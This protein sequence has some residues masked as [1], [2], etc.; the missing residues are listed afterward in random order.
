MQKPDGGFLSCWRQTVK[1][2]GFTQ[3]GKILCRNGIKWS[4]EMK[5]KDEKDKME[6]MHHHKVAQMIESA[7][8]SAGLLHKILMLA[9]WRGGAQILVNEEKDARLL[10]RCEAKRKEWAKTFAV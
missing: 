4:E 5:K 10:D 6:E 2:R 1:K 7:E 3:E 9:T 8:G